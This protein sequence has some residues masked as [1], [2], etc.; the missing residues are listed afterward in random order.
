[1]PPLYSCTDTREASKKQRML[2][3]TCATYI[4]GCIHGIKLTTHRRIRL[5]CVSVLVG[6]V[7]VK[8]KSHAPRNLCVSWCKSYVSC[9]TRAGV[10]AG[11][12][13]R[14]NATKSSPGGSLGQQ[15]QQRHVVSQM[16]GQAGLMN[17]SCAYCRKY[18][19][20]HDQGCHECTLICCQTWP[21]DGG[22][23]YW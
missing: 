23:L 4:H 20:K 1:M 16:P 10:C 7:S 9:C 13:K 19:H 3:V 18:M 2:H 12:T 17:A 5:E 11:I 8:S 14:H 22:A 15:T 6:L 21:C